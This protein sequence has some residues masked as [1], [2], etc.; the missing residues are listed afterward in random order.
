MK[1]ND[2][3]LHPQRQSQFAIFFIILRVLRDMFKQLWPILIA[4]FI[5]RGSSSFDTFEMALAGLGIFGIIPSL[6][7]Y[8]KFYFHLSENELIINKGLFRKVKLNIPVERIQS[9]NFRQTFIHQFF[10]VT[11]VVIE[12]AGSA[13][14]ET[15]IDAVTI[16]V[17][18]QLRKRILQKRALALGES[19]ET[20]QT[21][22]APES[23]ESI[24]RLSRN[25]LLRVGLVQNHFKPI[26]L[27]FGLFGSIFFYSYT[28]DYDPRD[29]YR[30]I[31]DYGDNLSIMDFVVIALILAIAS[32]AYS[33][34]TTVLRHYN[35]HFWRSGK[36]FQVV[37]GLLTR[38]EFAALDKKIQ[39][40]NWG[41]N[42]FERMVGFYNIIFRQAKSGDEGKQASRFK[43][44]GCVEDDIHFV[45]KSWQGEN[46][47]IF[48]NYLP[49]SIHWFYHGLYYQVFFFFYRKS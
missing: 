23:I 30:Q 20:V 25:D 31:S 18:E 45:Q 47:G 48:E 1:R 28:F 10:Q 16:P 33:V 27:L 2:L 22:D 29:F 32:V 11:E 38:Q 12:T 43:I 49:V 36:K 5:G 34:V 7:A 26:G 6:I 40:L 4:I 17:A 14:Q 35:L 37:Q 46:S 9:V 39:I 44:P 13:E 41:Q 19:R 42:P 3:F 8:F 21:S 15:K 24:V